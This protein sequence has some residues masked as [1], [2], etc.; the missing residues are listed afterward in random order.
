MKTLE[1]A[2]QTVQ[3]LIIDDDRIDA[4]V[5]KRLLKKADINNPVTHASDAHQALKTLQGWEQNPEGY[6]PVLVFLDLRMPR[7]SGA[8]LLARL[9]TEPF[10]PYLNVLVVTTSNHPKDRQTLS[11]HSIMG[12]INKKDLNNN[13]HQVLTHLT[14]NFELKSA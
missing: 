11:Q 8:E 9:E 13:F 3:C 5:L 2:G 6:P 14:E 12:F 10:A 4:E 7:M 1:Q